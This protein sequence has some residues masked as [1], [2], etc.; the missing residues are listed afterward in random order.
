MV[1]P[2]VWQEV[3]DSHVR[4]AELLD[5]EV[6][7]SSG[8]GDTQ[9]AQDNEMGIAVLVQWAARVEVVDT[10]TEAVG[11]ALAAPLP[12]SLVVVVARHVGHEIVGPANDLL[13]DQVD[14]GG[15]W[16][17]LSQFR[18]LVGEATKTAGL[19]FPGPGNEDHVTLNVSGG[20][21]VLAVAHLPAEVGNKQGGVED[22]A[23]Q[24]VDLLRRRESS[25]AALVS[26][27]PE[28]GAEQTLEERVHAPEDDADGLRGNVLGS[29]EVVPD[30]KSRGKANHIPDDIT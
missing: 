29:D 22:P 11:L 25:V 19:L 3:P 20:L 2:Y 10:A 27:H 14:E 13:A 28:T 16:C 9:V 26:Q 24:I 5:Q 4:P 6:K 18:Q 23:D 12:L 30:V 8:D 21:V 7:G 17:L 1:D 15:N